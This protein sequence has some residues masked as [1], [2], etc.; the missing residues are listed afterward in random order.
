MRDS[1]SLRWESLPAA[2]ACSSSSMSDNW[3]VMGPRRA[4][5]SLLRPAAWPG[6]DEETIAAERAMIGVNEAA[7]Q[8]RPVVTP[9]GE[10]LDEETA[11]MRRKE[12]RHCVTDSSMVN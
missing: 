8:G 5:R 3:A 9:H 4:R 6:S 12:R 2:S 11:K 1:M 7:D 10:D